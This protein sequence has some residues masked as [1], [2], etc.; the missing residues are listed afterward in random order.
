MAVPR[1]I[2]GHSQP[3]STLQDRCS[4][5]PASIRKCW[6]GVKDP[7]RDLFLLYLIPFFAIMLTSLVLKQQ[8]SNFL[9]LKLAWQS[10]GVVVIGRGSLDVSFGPILLALF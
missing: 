5:N 2:G 3:I 4:S 7:W 6:G 9:V 10:K 8:D 1:E